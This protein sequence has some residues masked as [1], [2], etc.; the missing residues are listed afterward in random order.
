MSEVKTRPIPTAKE[1]SSELEAILEGLDSTESEW[2]RSHYE[3]RVMWLAVK[4][5][6]SLVA[7]LEEGE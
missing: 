5:L 2:L 3:K 7:V 6:I 1:L 4:A